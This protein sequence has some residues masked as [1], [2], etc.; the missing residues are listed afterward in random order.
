MTTSR[1]PTM[2]RT[3]FLA[4]FVVVGL[5]ACGSAQEAV[6]EQLVEQAVGGDVDIELDDDGQVASIETEDGSLT[7]VTGGDVPEEWPAD[8]PLFDGGVLESS[9]VITS[10]G[11]TFVSIG[12]TTDADPDETFESLVAAYEAAGFTAA[13]ESTMGDS[14][15]GISSYV[16]QRGEITVTMGVLSGQDSPTG[17][18][19][20][21]VMPAG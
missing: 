15:G 12:Y 1:F 2:L 14:S 10:D 18:N 5:A 4:P 3:G 8:V 20:G 7:A 19:F 9:Q 21:L 13:S 6:S 17:V 11:E 16:G